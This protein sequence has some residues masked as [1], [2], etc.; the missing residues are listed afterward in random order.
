MIS[1]KIIKQIAKKENKNIGKEAIKKIQSILI[2]KTEEIIKKSARNADFAGRKT[3][4]LADV[5]EAQI[6]SN[7]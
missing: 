4:K 2:G 7:N 6:E 5:Q 3:I 1:S